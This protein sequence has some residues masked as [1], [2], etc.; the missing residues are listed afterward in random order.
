MSYMKL[1]KPTIAYIYTNKHKNTF[2]T[3]KHMNKI[4]AYK[5]QVRAQKQQIRAHKKQIGARK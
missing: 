5:K 3:G 2:K 4:W 1:L